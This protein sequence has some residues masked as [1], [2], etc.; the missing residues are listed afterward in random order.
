MGGQEEPGGLCL[1]TWLAPSS[2]RAL[3]SLDLLPSVLQVRSG[4]CSWAHWLG[5]SSQGVLLTEGQPGPPTALRAHLDAASSARMWPGPCF[6]HRWVLGHPQPP[7]KARTGGALSPRAAAPQDTAGP[8]EAA[9]AEAGWSS[10]PG[11]G[12]VA[13]ESPGESRR[14]GPRQRLHAQTEG[15]AEAGRKAW[16]SG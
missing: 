3:S 16:G 13:L 14:A 7:P 12:D 1:E 11:P 9:V 8:H 15:Q 10:E 6:S 5:Q 4:W 2:L